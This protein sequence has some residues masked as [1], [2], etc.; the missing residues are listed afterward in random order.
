MARQRA[1]LDDNY[2]ETLSRPTLRQQCWKICFAVE[3]GQES[4]ILIAAPIC[5]ERWKMGA[6]ET[7]PRQ[8]SLRRCGKVQSRE[9]KCLGS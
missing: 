7:R 1:G 2:S 6:M 4:S 8:S 9:R 5:C 3:A